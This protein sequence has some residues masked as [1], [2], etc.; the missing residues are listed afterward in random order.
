ME[1]KFPG[2]PLSLTVRC[3]A[4]KQT[5]RSA[6]SQEF[7]TV[8]QKLFSGRM[9]SLSL[10]KNS[11]V[12]Y[13]SAACCVQEHVRRDLQALGDPGR[14]GRT[15]VSARHRSGGLQEMS[16]GHNSSPEA[17]C[18][19]WAWRVGFSRPKGHLVLLFW[20]LL[21]V[22]RSF[23]LDKVTCK[24][25]PYSSLGSG[26]KQ[27]PVKDAKLIFSVLLT[28]V[29][30]PLFSPLI[31]PRL[32]CH[33]RAWPRLGAERCPCSPPASWA[34]LWTSPGYPKPASGPRS[35]E[36]ACAACGRGLLEL[37]FTARAGRPGRTRR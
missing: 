2:F 35:R 3:S 19:P 12:L 29:S 14:R 28:T 27:E 18:E 8:L 10:F 16:A 26:D 9:T 32:S 22:L 25:G 20:A 6:R 7:N 4:V 37:C 13:K 1:R 11:S 21:P 30:W 17:H 33:F 36:P 31:V 15:L 23:N 24:W 5:L 34:E